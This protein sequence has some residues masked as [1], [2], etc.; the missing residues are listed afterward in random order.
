M[1]EKLVTGALLLSESAWL[2]A[3]LGILS[4]PF[5]ATGS[6]I[7]WLAVLAVM[8]VSLVWARTLSMIVMPPLMAYGLQMLAGVIVVFLTVASQVSPETGALHLGWIGTMLSG[9]APESFI[10]RGVYGTLGGAALWWRGGHIGAADIPAESLSSS[11]RIGVLILSI[12]AVIDIFHT[13]RPRRVPH[14]V[15]LLRVPESRA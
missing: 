1:R 10:L 3:L 12:A 15:H 14:D 2:V 5:G 13:R 11:F 8:S 6:P 7:S 9:E 4:F